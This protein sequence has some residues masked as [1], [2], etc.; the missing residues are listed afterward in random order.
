MKKGFYVIVNGKQQ[1]PYGV[2][3]LKAMGIQKDTLIWT[4]GLDSWTKAEYVSILK[5]VLRKMPPPIPNME[6]KKSK[7]EKFTSAN[8]RST[9]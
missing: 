2:A 9:K 7:Q 4:E 6:T 3:D 1:G 5:D 8:T